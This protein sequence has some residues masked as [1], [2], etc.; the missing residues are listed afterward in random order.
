MRKLFG[1]AQLEE[2]RRFASPIKN[3]MSCNRS[4][5]FGYFLKPGHTVASGDKLLSQEIS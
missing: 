1:D 5:D 2:A 4:L 3:I